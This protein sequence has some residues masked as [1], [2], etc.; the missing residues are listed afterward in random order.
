MK[1]L[2]ALVLAGIMVFGVAACS[3]KPAE[4]TTTTAT[5]EAKEDDYVVQIVQGASLCTAPMYLA[6]TN[7]YFD[8]LGV[9]YEY[10]RGDGAQWDAMAGDKNDIVYGLLPTFVQR[11][12]NGFEMYLVSGS[13]YGCINVVATDASGI[14]SIS[15][16]KGRTVGIPSGLGSDPAIL[17]QRMLVAYGIDLTEVNLQVYTNADLATALQEGYVEAFVSWDPYATIVSQ[18]EGNHLIF[19]QAK[20]PMTADEYCCLFG[21]RPEF[22]DE[23]PEIAKKCVQAFTMAC[24]F[25][26]ENPVEAAKIIYDEGFIADPD[27]EFNGK[28]LESYRY[29]TDFAATKASFVDVA[30]DLVDLGII[31]LTVDS[32]TLADQVFVNIGEIE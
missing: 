9:K 27:Y 17:L 23:H 29:A 1:K 20:D 13:H 2:L 26:A 19:D 4:T 21:F 28:L 16:L 7:G 12:A 22:V 18:Y 3:S 11:I 6:M 8:E 5:T 10:T 25:I 14:Q 32:Q 15:D 24:E 31:T 30:N